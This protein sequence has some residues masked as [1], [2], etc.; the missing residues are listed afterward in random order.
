MVIIGMRLIGEYCQRMSSSD[1]LRWVCVAN[2]FN[3]SAQAGFLNFLSNQFDH[4]G[5][6]MIFHESMVIPS[7]YTGEEQLVL[8]RWFQKAS[9]GEDKKNL[10]ESSKVAEIVLATIQGKLPKGLSISEDG[11]AIAGR[12]TWQLTVRMR[13]DVIYPVHLLAIDWEDKQQGISWP[14]V[15]YWT[16]LPGYDVYVVTISMDSGEFY[17]YADLAIGF[18]RFEDVAFMAQKASEVV[19]AW[20]KY[21]HQGMHKP[22]WKAFVKPGLINSEMAYRMREEEWDIVGSHDKVIL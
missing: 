5:G 12:K 14:E 4:R 2:S 16:Y 21:L 11:S 20:W 17:G 13:S 9:A 19:R 10:E 18:F 15:Y 3:I 1:F 8:E 7:L 6:N 22:V